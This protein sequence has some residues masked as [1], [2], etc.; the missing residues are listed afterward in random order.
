MPDSRDSSSADPASCDRLGPSLDPGNSRAGVNTWT[1]GGPADTGNVSASLVAAN[2]FGSL[3]RV[4]G[5]RRVGPVPERRRRPGLDSGRL[6]WRHSVAARS[7]DD[8]VGPVRGRLGP[9]ARWAASRRAGWR[10]DLEDCGGTGVFFQFRACARS[11]RDESS[12]VF[13]G[14]FVQ[15]GPEEPGRRRYLVAGPFKYWDL[16]RDCFSLRRPPGRGD[17][18][19]RHRGRHLLPHVGSLHPELGCW[20]QLGRSVS[21]TNGRSFGDCD[22]SRHFDALRRTAR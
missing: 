8:A 16:G 1:G 4:R 11:E 6:V 21:R 15:R 13:R 14:N 2:P 17:D 18:L 22:R 9:D 19:S 7:S 10:P 5:L 12:R 3:R 20:S